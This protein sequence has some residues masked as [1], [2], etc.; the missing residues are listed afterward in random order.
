MS[1]PKSMLFYS[2]PY[3]TFCHLL[4][5]HPPSRQTLKSGKL[6]TIWAENLNKF[7]I[8]DLPRVMQ[9]SPR[10]LECTRMT[11]WKL[12]IWILG[13]YDLKIWCYNIFKGLKRHFAPPPMS[14]FVTLLVNS[15][16]SPLWRV[17]NSLNDALSIRKS[18]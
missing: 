8:L 1:L 10:F 4:A 7:Y 12:K 9:T 11:N 15:P 17:R 16:S 3:V 6:K 18:T 2:S 13:W 14:K 5:W